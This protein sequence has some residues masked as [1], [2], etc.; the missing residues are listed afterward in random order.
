[1][2]P[3]EVIDERIYE[4]RPSLIIATAD[5]LAMLAFKPR[6]GEI[7]GRSDVHGARKL[8]RLPPGTCR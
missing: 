4:T 2:L 7:F 3:V 6:A 8:T 5:K 1:M